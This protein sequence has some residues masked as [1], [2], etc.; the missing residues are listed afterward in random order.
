VKIAF[1]EEHEQWRKSVRSFMEQKSPEKEVRRLMGTVDGFDIDV[2]KQMADQLG[3]QA[4]TIPEEYGGSGFGFVE[5]GIVFEEMGRIL[6]CAPLFS[7]AV[8]ATGALLASGDEGAKKTYLP[9]L[10]SG[11][12]IA[13]LA[14]TEGVGRWE[15]HAISTRATSRGDDWLLNGVK[16]FVVDGHLAKLVLVAARSEAGVSLFAVDAGASGLSVTPM[17]TLDQTRKLSEVRFEDVPARL[18]GSEGK[19]WPAIAHVLNLAAVALAAESAGGAQHCLEMSVSYAKIRKQ[20]GRVIGSFQAIKHKCA[21]MLL[22]VE[23]AKSAAYYAMWAADEEAG[24]LPVAA[25]LAKSF[26]TEAYF[27]VAAETIQIHGGIGFTWE[28]SAHLYFK[29]AKSI[30]LLFGDPT[31]HRELMAQRLGV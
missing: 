17:D 6:M 25:S 10:A 28:H 29:R 5:L 15:E 23:S 31:F 22:E 4:L 13:T 19:A 26:C 1:T 12:T 11:E 16:T 14:V 3:L 27:H 18:V 2:W 9:S 24:E 7:T 20:F 30:E 8:L 21:D